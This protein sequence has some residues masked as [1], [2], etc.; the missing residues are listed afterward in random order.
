MSFIKAINDICL[1][2][3]KNTKIEIL[4]NVILGSLKKNCAV[5]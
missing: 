3:A 5:I 1:K 4:V 2:D